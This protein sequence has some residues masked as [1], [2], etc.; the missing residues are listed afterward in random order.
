MPVSRAAINTAAIILMSAAL[1]LAHCTF[2]SAALARSEEH[3]PELQSPMYVVCR[4]LL[5]KKKDYWRVKPDLTLS[6]KLFY[7]TPTNIYIIF[8]LAAGFVF[9]R[10]PGN[11]TAT[12]LLQTVTR[13]GDV[14][15]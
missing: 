1:L 3:T 2:A 11:A 5:E 12:R 7:E 4:L 10:L 14:I 13:I 15:F 8:T 9:T 6:Y